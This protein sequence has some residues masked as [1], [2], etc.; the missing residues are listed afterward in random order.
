VVLSFGEPVP[1]AFK[2]DI[3]LWQV[4]NY[5][6]VAL[7]TTSYG[8]NFPPFIYLDNPI[9]TNHNMNCVIMIMLNI[10]IY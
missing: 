5:I 7:S 2:R 6:G 1:D 9:L 10:P 4:P 8:H 3:G